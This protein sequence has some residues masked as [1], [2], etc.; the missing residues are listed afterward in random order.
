M[1]DAFNMPHMCL[2]SSTSS[3]FSS[4]K[5]V[6]ILRDVNSLE[7]EKPSKLFIETLTFEKKIPMVKH[8]K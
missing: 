5:N 4:E 1:S 8:P 7:R 6:L 2:F 3:D